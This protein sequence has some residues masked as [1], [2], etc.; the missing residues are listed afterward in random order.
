[1]HLLAAGASDESNLVKFVE[2]FK[3]ETAVEFAPMQ[4]SA[5]ST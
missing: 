2:S 1:M 4:K 5:R 3:Q